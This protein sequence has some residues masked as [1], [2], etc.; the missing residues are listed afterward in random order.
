MSTESGSCST[1]S[2]KREFTELLEEDSQIDDSQT[3]NCDLSPP[4]KKRKLSEIHPPKTPI[5]TPSST[6]IHKKKKKHRH[7]HR[8]HHHSHHNHNHN[9]NNINKIPI[10]RCISGSVIYFIL[11]IFMI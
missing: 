11:F 1:Q 7:R 8:H 2:L 10:V 9:H 4:R 5:L 3:D 6:H